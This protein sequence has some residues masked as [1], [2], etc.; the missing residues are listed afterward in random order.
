MA[1]D[2]VIPNNIT[3]GNDFIF[4]SGGPNNIIVYRGSIA[5]QGTAF[6]VSK[7]IHSI[8]SPAT[9]V[10]KG[11]AFLVTNVL[12]K[13]GYISNPSI[14][15]RDYQHITPLVDPVDTKRLVDI[16]IPGLSPTSTYNPS[17]ATNSLIP[18]TTFTLPNGVVTTSF[19]ELF[20]NRIHINP[21]KIDFGIIANDNTIHLTVWN[22]TVNTITLND[23]TQSNLDGSGVTIANASQPIPSLGIL[24]TSISV[25]TNGI[26][27]V[28][29][30]FSID[31]G[32]YRAALKVNGIRA[33]I[34]PFRVLKDYSESYTW[35]TDVNQA[36]HGE[37]RISLTDYPSLTL[38]Y[39]Y[40]FDNQLEAQTARNIASLVTTTYVG[41]PMWSRGFKGVS[42]TVGGSAFSLNQSALKLSL[43]DYVIII[44]NYSKYEIVKILT[45]SPTSC[46]IDNVF[47]LTQTN[48][49]IAPFITGSLG[50]AI[51]FKRSAGG[52]IKASL[53]LT[54]DVYQYPYIYSPTMLNSLPLL[55][56]KRDITS[57]ET[58]DYKT[59]IEIWDN[60]GI[61]VRTP[62]PLDDYNRAGQGLNLLSTHGA[63]TIEY[64]SLF[65][66][67]KGRTTPFYLPFYYDTMTAVS[68]IM[69]GNAS[70]TIVANAT[71]RITLGKVIKIV[72]EVTDYFTITGAT[73]SSNSTEILTLSP[74][75]TRNINNIS[76]V[77]L[78]LKV[79]LASDTVNVSYSSNIV[80]IATKTLEIL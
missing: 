48:A 46:T 54:S 16:L 4:S 40:N 78:V 62:L 52:G 29:G 24:T 7:K 15:L 12:S 1:N 5:I 71:S 37:E 58:T 47:A 77:G 28:N 65:Y 41:V 21:N 75:P 69:S 64:I 67:L 51:S 9:L 27:I 31:S 30:E 13:I 42:T 50:E 2:F 23:F 3:T 74:I 66:Y 79:R 38:N 55:D 63:K 36:R 20:Y 59:D 53:Q 17:P 60:S 43:G 18:S 14:Q 73:T 61:G 39:N 25:T 72:G 70:F 10:V 68:P 45:V 35:V 34:F 19:T 44:T 33:I 56:I 32:G 8:V 11:N 22:S 76:S 80:R 57:E 6:E 49:Y 26:P